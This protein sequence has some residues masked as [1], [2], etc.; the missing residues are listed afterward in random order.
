MKKVLNIIKSNLLIVIVMVVTILAL[1]AMIFFSS[2]WAA[3]IHEEV[4]KRES[5]N[6]RA[7]D[8]IT[9]TYEIPAVVP[10]EEA[11]SIRATPNKTT[12]ERVAELRKGVYE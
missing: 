7:I 6:I 9:V 11:V 10:G 8:G 5:S 1:P 3:S 2:K 12:T 4:E